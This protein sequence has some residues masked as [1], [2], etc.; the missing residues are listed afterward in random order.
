M[1]LVIDTSSAVSAVALLRPDGSVA[2]EQTGPSGPGFELAN[3]VRELRQGHPLSKVAVATGP[4]SF[5]GLRVGV[6]FGLGLAIGS[7]VAIVPLSTLALQAARSLEPALAVSEAGRGR[8]Y[9]Q[10]PDQS[11]GLSEPGELPKDWPA[12]GWLRPATRDALLAAG[13]R[14]LEESRLRSFGEAAAI[15]LE[16]AREVAY[17]NLKLEYMQSFASKL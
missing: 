10:A 9:Y 3:R 6:S 11:P 8:V 2:G 13:V 15:T 5:T 7:K 1:I 14:M 17:D 16:T 4:G 12:V